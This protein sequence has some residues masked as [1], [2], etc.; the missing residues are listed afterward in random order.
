VLRS[1]ADA[2]SGSESLW[3][4]RLPTGQLGDVIGKLAAVA[5]RDEI[6]KES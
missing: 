6:V 3:P 4:R 5:H 1:S 2:T